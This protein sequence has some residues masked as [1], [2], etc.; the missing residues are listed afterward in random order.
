MVNRKPVNVVAE[1]P[2]VKRILRHGR[3]RENINAIPAI[4]ISF[5]CYRGPLPGFG[6]RQAAITRPCM[7]VSP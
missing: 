5:V 4:S 6:S 3:T 7:L 2:A 1:L